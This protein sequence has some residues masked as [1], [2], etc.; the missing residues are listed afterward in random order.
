MTV[1]VLGASG[2]IGSYLAARLER[3]G[4]R[5][6]AA[7]R[8]LRR[9]E[10]RF[11]GRAVRID[12]AAATPEDWGEAL[13]GVEAVVNCAGALQDSL[14]DD[15]R[16]V[17]ATGVE[18]LLAGCRTAG[19][20]RYLHISAAGLAAER[21][22][23]F[24]RTKLAG[25]AAV[26]ATGLDWIILRPGLVLAPAA[27]GGSALLRALAAFPL[28]IPA[29]W[30]DREVQV[31]GMDDLAT[32]VAA[33]LEP[34]AATGVVVD[35]LHAERIA[36]ADLLKRL[37]GWLGFAPAP[38][39]AV[40]PVAA[41]AAARVADGLGWLGWRSPMRSASLEQLRMG[42]TGDGA[43]SERV[44][45][46]APRPLDAVLAAA[47]AGVQERWFARL[48][49]LKPVV[50]GAL[51]AFWVSSGVIGLLSFE[52]AR[53]VLTEAGAP[54]GFSGM[55]VLGGSL[56]DLALGLAVLVRPWAR[57]ALWGMIGLSLAYLAG[58]S[59]VRPDLWLEPLGP[60]VKTIPAMVLALMALA[61]LDD[62]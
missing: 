56:A 41:R 28:A 43:A 31:I 60:L 10:R 29:V 35:V 50:L 34:G 9:L 13:A 37:R 1:L 25:E 58:A 30:A 12:L 17:H 7:G 61:V 53:A 15:L 18:A 39:L 23:G 40:P 44:L 49:L 3:D 42:V 20:K 33:A 36:L 19:V 38:V 48:Y 55:A 62:R 45:G 54:A 4:R 22:T 8:D 26:A 16:A 2:L 46:V 57:G 6:I 14:G 24:N 51:A 27:Y 59:L 5:V 21:T 47:P 11:P 52:A 32:A